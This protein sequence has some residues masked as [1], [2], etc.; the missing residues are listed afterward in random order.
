MKRFKGFVFLFGYI[1][2]TLLSSF[3]ANIAYNKYYIYIKDYDF[4][5]WLLYSFFGLYY[6][7]N[8]VLI[9]LIVY[10]SIE[11]FVLNGNLSFQE[12]LKKF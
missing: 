9:S 6:I 2:L 3:I 5:L 1:F 4:F 7:F 12:F 10:F 11:N 8:A